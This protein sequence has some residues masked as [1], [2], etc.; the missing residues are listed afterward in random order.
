MHDAVGVHDA[1]VTP[2]ALV[3]TRVDLRRLE[4]RAARLEPGTHDAAVLDALLTHLRGAIAVDA[5]DVPEDVVT[6][7]SGVEIRD[8]ESGRRLSFTVVAPDRADVADGRISVLAP[9]GAAVYG[10]RVGRELRWSAPAGSRRARLEA[11]RY[12]PESARRADGGW[13]VRAADD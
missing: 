5:A 8:L 4:E 3:V 2:D 6:L 11:V 9:L 7:D 1:P 12:Q 10:Q 13:P